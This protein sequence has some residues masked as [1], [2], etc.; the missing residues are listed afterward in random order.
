[1]NQLFWKAVQLVLSLYILA[2]L[3]TATARL[4]VAAWWVIALAVIALVVAKLWWRRGAR[5]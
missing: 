5:W 4:I 2:V 1:V 3:V